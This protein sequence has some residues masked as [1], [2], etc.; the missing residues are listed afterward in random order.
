MQEQHDLYDNNLN[1]LPVEIL[2]NIADVDR[3]NLLPIL[4][5]VTKGL[6]NLFQPQRL[7][8][9][10]VKHILNHDIDDIISI[11]SLHPGLILENAFFIDDFSKFD[12]AIVFELL[13]AAMHHEELLRIVKE[14]IPINNTGMKILTELPNYFSGLDV[15]VI[16]YIEDGKV[17]EEYY[18]YLRIPVLLLKIFIM[19]FDFLNHDER[20]DFFSIIQRSFKKPRFSKIFSNRLY[21]NNFASLTEN[22]LSNIDIDRISDYSDSEYNHE[23][24]SIKFYTDRFESYIKHFF[25]IY[26]LTKDALIQYIDERSIELELQGENLDFTHQARS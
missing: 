5:L 12:G 21:S 2:I 1:N 15:K 24:K 18:N 13:I 4:V 10:L 17:R 22:N 3:K 26:S 7:T 19:Q 23:L 25:P 20:K 14:S 11:L 8:S 6:Y 9:K 16:R